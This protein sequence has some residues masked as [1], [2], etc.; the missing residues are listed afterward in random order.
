MLIYHGSFCV[1]QKPKI[2]YSRDKLNFGKGFY[3]TPLMEQ[4]EAWVARFKRTGR[5]AIVNCYE[6]DENKVCQNYRIKK[7]KEY[8]DEW[9]DFIIACRNGDLIYQ[10]YDV[11][12]GG[13]ANDKVF[14][15]VEL[16]M[17]G[18]ISKYEAL[19]RLKYQQPNYQICFIN[20]EVINQ[21]LLFKGSSEK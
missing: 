17:D 11:V 16:F 13:I 8:D 5:N 20:Q 18:L 14:N 9:L 21:Y 3:V 10:E 15:T 2:E 19:G 4:A 6:Y 7:F 1:I 12:E